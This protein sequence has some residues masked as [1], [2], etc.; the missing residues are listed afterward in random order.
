[1]RRRRVHPRADDTKPSPHNE[2]EGAVAKI[3]DEPERERGEPY[4]NAS[5]VP[6]FDPERRAAVITH[7]P[8]AY[9]QIATSSPL[10]FTGAAAETEFV[11]DRLFPGNPL[12]CCAKAQHSSITRSR[13]EWRDTK[14]STLQYIVPSAMCART[15]ISQKHEVSSRS[16]DN[17]GPR[18]F[19][20]IEQDS[21]TANDQAAILLDLA[22]AFSLVMVVFSGKSSLHGWFCVEG[23]N[24]NLIEKFYDRACRHG[25]DNATRS[26]CQLVRVPG[27][28]RQNGV[29]QPIIYFD[30]EAIVLHPASPPPAERYIAEVTNGVLKGS[31]ADFSVP[32]FP[33]GLPGDVVAVLSSAPP[34]GKGLLSWIPPAAMQLLRGGRSPTEVAQ[35]LH[36][37]TRHYPQL[38]PAEIHSL[39]RCRL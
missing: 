29:R 27:G 17:T 1:M 24:Q 22:N 33:P 3:Y 18:R 37:V 38:T 23:E 36:L 5:S 15:G 31:E 2:V 39:K 25:A 35:L 13:E 12:I 16:L 7:Y 10:I 11:I 28:T 14:L 20:V 6:K 19:A 4:V 34:L 26:R 8:R 30:P 32:V 9:R 21:G